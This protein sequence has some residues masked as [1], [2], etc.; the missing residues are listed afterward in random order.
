MD[1]DV[2]KLIMDEVRGSLRSGGSK[3]FAELYQFC[4][5]AGSQQEL[6][7]VL[8]KMSAQQLIFKR[9]LDGK[10]F[11]NGEMQAAPMPGPVHE[12]TVQDEAADEKKVDSLDAG[13][14]QHDVVPQVAVEEGKTMTKREKLLRCLLTGAANNEQIGKATRLTQNDISTITSQLRAAGCINTD[15]D[16]VH[17]ITAIGKQR[18]EKKNGK[19]E[20]AVKDKPEKVAKEKTSRK[21]AA[22]KK[23]NGPGKHPCDNDADEVELLLTERL[24]QVESSL[25]LFLNVVADNNSELKELLEARDRIRDALDAYRGKACPF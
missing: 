17:S 8:G 1:D 11:L 21:K 22:G 2:L 20:K 3:S 19:A 25:W 9:P 7:L 16:K 4:E 5:H 12:Q 10:Y 18:L 6:K 13:L 15:A 14:R 23:G 24:M